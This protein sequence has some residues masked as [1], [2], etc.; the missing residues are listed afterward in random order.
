MVV[1]TVFKTIAL[2]LLGIWAYLFIGALC[3]LHWFVEFQGMDS[4]ERPFAFLFWPLYPIIK[5]FQLEV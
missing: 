3:C 1:I 4:K 5:A 2:T